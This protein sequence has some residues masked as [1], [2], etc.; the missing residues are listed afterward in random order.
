M[1]RQPEYEKECR[2]IRASMRD[3][4][5]EE[6]K[7]ASIGSVGITNLTQV[8]RKIRCLSE[9]TIFGKGCVWISCSCLGS[10]R[11]SV[12]ICGKKGR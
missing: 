7:G 3:W 10:A 11:S 4:I 5:V 9:T 12:L 6:I 2:W 8:R 1:I